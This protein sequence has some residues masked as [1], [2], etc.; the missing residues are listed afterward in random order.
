LSRPVNY[1]RLTAPEL[2]AVFNHPAVNQHSQAS[3]ERGAPSLKPLERAAPVVVTVRAEGGTL[4]GHAV[5]AFPSRFPIQV[6]ILGKHPGPEAVAELAGLCFTEVGLCGGRR[7][8]IG[9]MAKQG[10]A[11]FPYAYPSA[12]AIEECARLPQ[13]PELSGWWIDEIDGWKKTPR[14]AQEMLR[15]ADAAMRAAGLPL[16]PHCMN[17]MA[18]WGDAGYIELAD[19]LSH[20]YGIDGGIGGQGGCRAALDFGAP[21]DI[22]RRELRTARRPWWPYFRNIEAALI[23]EPGTQQVAAHYRPIDPRELRLYVYSCLANG[24]KGALHWNY[25]LNFLTPKVSTWL[26][27]THDAIRLNMTALK[28]DEAFGVPV[29][30]EIRDG[31]RAA[32]HEC[33][34]INAELQLLG[35]HLAMGDV[36]DLAAVARCAPERGPRGGPAGHARAIACGLDTVVLVAVNLNIESNFNARKPEPV[37]KYEPVAMDV[38]LRVPPWLRP[39]DVFR[40]TWRGVEALSPEKRQ[41]GLRISFAKLEVAEAVVITADRGLRPRMA[42][43]LAALQAK[44]RAAGVE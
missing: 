23:L 44:L 37:K 30:R 9:E 32:T 10:L 21:G 34:R 41:E 31:L 1:S 12:K 40:V 5:R 22:S 25:G 38:D 7:E 15:Q 24:A 20:E 36:S 8:L 28:E 29:P 33:G 26:S 13:P 4:A 16:A 18:P 6:V 19:A 39:A 17:L 2:T 14:D 35:P 42:R 43:D 11:Y 3:I 27:T